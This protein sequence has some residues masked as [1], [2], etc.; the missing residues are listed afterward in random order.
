MF[1]QHLSLKNFQKHSSL[2]I[3]FT[4]KFTVLYGP[5]DA[6]KSTVIRAI[7]WVLFNEPKG[8]SLIRE[9]AKSASVTILFSNG[10]E[11]ERKKSKTVNSYTLRKDGKETVF[12]TVGKTIPQEIKDALQIYPFETE[13]ETIFLNIA[14]Q[15]EMPFLCE[16]SGI[17]RGKIFNKLTGNDIADKVIQGLNKDILACGRSVNELDTNL[18]N[19][20]YEFNS[21]SD[22]IIQKTELFQKVEQ[23]STALEQ[24]QKRYDQLLQIK[25]SLT[26]TEKELSEIAIPK[27]PSISVD[28]VQKNIIRYDELLLLSVRLEKLNA[29]EKENYYNLQTKIAEETNLL[30]KKES[31]KSQIRVCPTCGQEVPHV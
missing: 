12:E 27:L 16:K 15:L 30:T 3:D 31:I 20:T 21:V 1:I 2:D 13:E 6:G 5:T 23:L 22:D 7:K 18:E 25:Q 10:V 11:V 26:S 28:I 17:T 9:G 14:G 4:D 24:N 29:D 8:D 19:L